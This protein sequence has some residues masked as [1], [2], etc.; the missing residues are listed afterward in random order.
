MAGTFD[1]R[2][3][4]LIDECD[5]GG[6]VIG[7]V[8]FNQV[9]A[10]RQHYETSW[11]H[12]RGGQAMYLTE[13]LFGN[14][15]T[16]LSD[17]AATAI[18]PDGVEVTVGMIDATE[19]VAQDASQ[20]APLMWGNLK[21]SAHVT[22]THNGDVIYERPALAARL[23]DDELDALHELWEDLHPE[24]QLG[25]TGYSDFIKAIAGLP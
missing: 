10:H 21:M 13:A 17:L 11:K 16:F 6:V 3:D 4:L 23:T 15:G 5:G 2:I 25:T 19:A 22:V 8:E 20:R 14:V 9:Y 12:P 24:G 18:T 7:K 1:E